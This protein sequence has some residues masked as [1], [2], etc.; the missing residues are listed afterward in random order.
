MGKPTVH[1]ETL[2]RAA[3]VLGSEERLAGALRVPVEQLRKWMAGEEYAPTKVY[4]KALDVLI[5]IGAG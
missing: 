4:Q 2:Q 1:A 3:L 5:G